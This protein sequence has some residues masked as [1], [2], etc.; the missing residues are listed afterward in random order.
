MKC[1]ESPEKL[2]GKVWGRMEP[3]SGGKR[4]IEVLLNFRRTILG[5]SGLF[6]LGKWKMRVTDATAVWRNGHETVD[7]QGK[8]LSMGHR[9][10][11]NSDKIH[12]KT[13]ET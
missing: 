12:L 10:L 6:D 2:F 8:Y 5:G 3:S 1:G 4:P 7:V 11:D 9:S 13:Q